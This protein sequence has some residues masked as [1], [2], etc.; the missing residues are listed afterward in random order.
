MSK[1][2]SIDIDVFHDAPDGLWFSVASL[3]DGFRGINNR[4]KR[5][6][7][8]G[9]IERGAPPNEHTFKKLPV[10][11]TCTGCSWIGT[12]D[13]CERVEIFDYAPIQAWDN[14][15]PRCRSNTFYKLVR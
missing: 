4:L 1:V 15:C 11:I 12:D 13:D 3:S 5:M 6:V 9:L 14:V 10:T 8:L 2:S 7:K